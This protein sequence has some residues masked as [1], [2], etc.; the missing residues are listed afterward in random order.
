MTSL[1][2]LIAEPEDGTT[3]ALLHRTAEW[4]VIRRDDVRAQR[5]GFD[6]VYRWFE[7]A[8]GGELEPGSWRAFAY[9]ATRAFALGPLL[10]DL[11]AERG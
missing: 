6:G 7:I 3:V 10:A 5:L 1:A 8:V 2:D 11:E 4:V 9:K